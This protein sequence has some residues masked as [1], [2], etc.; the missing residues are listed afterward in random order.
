M[1][2]RWPY[3]Y[4]FVGCCFQDL[5][6][7]AGS[8]LVQCPSNFFSIDL[9]S[10]HGVSN[11]CNELQRWV[12]SHMDIAD[13]LS[14]LL[15]IVHRPGRSSGLDPVSSQSCCMYVRASRPTFT[16][17]YDGVHRSTS[18][19]SLSLLLQQCPAYL[20]RLT[21]IRIR[22]RLLYLDRLYDFIRMIMMVAKYVFSQFVCCVGDTKPI[23]AKYY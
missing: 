7:I 9:S 2:G 3:H 15:P 12:F 23:F 1:G 14:P 18:L 22:K 4:C 8:F 17:P 10:R 20:I 21:W 13:P 6:D 19:I 16:R 11:L 5:L